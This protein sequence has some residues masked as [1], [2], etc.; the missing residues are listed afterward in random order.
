M[1]RN[2]VAFITGACG[3]IG[4]ETAIAFA[5]AGYHIFLT[6]VEENCLSN[7]ADNLSKQ[8]GICV[9]FMAADLSQ[10]EIMLQ[11]VNKAER[12]LG[13]ISVLINNAAWRTISNMREMNVEDWQ[14]TI[15]VCLTA[16]AFLAKYCAA[17][18][19][20]QQTGG[21]IINISSIMAQKSAGNSP[22]YIAAKAGIE[23]L[24]RELAIT[25][26]RSGIRVLAIA[27]GYVNSPLSDQYKDEDNRSRNKGLQD[28]LLDLTPLNRPASPEEIARMLLWLAGSEAA[29]LSGST[30]TAD[31]GLTCNLTAY[32]I[33]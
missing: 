16:P 9:D 2:K 23:G 22:A 27:P 32:S 31:G 18:M 30:I 15:Q 33:K 5:S 8:F 12:Q 28:F 4:H 20:S 19:E 17:S 10:P 25:Y 26:G 29:F 1:I 24:T 7:I 13:S 21:V 6:D 14:K 11:L 3:A